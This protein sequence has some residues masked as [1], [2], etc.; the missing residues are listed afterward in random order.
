MQE[1]KFTRGT[2]QRMF[3]SAPTSDRNHQK[4]I[5][6]NL[7]S[8][9]SVVIACLATFCFGPLT[10]RQPVQ[11]IRAPSGLVRSEKI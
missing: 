5:S 10:P 9:Y 3:T 11:S 8:C 6:K 7:A 1:R 2:F 4:T